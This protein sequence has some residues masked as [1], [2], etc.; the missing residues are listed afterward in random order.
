MLKCRKWHQQAQKI[1][2][3]YYLGNQY[4]ITELTFPYN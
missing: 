1:Q 4:N 2:V 3:R